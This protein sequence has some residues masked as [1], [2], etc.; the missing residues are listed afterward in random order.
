M[1]SITNSCFFSF[2]VFVFCFC[3]CLTGVIIGLC[4]FGAYSY[5]KFK[6]GVSA[7]NDD[8]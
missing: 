5:E 4:S 6:N 2:F 1:D 3:F 8:V 7:T